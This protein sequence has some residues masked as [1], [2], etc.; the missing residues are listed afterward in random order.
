MERRQSMSVVNY[1]TRGERPVRRTRGATGVQGMTIDPAVIRTSALKVG[2]V[3]TNHE[4]TSGLT[5]GRYTILAASS[6]VQAQH[7]QGFGTG[8]LWPSELG[9]K[10]W[11][12]LDRV[13]GTPGTPS[14]GYMRGATERVL[15]LLAC[16]AWMKA[17]KAGSTVTDPLPLGDSSTAT[18]EFK[19]TPPH[20]S[21][22]PDFAQLAADTVSRYTQIDRVVIWN[23]FKGFWSPTLGR[24]WYEGYTNMYNQCYAA[25]KAVRP[26]VKVG[27]PYMVFNTQG[28][29]FPGDWADDAEPVV[30]DR[31][32]G[33]S[34]AHWGYA[35]KKVLASVKY[36]LANATAADFF[37]MD[38]R[39]STKD[40]AASDAENITYTAAKWDTNPEGGTHPYYW[41]TDPWSAWQKQADM[42][43]WFRSLGAASPSSWGRAGVD[44]RT[45]PFWFMEWYPNSKVNNSTINPNTGTPYPDPVSSDAEKNTVAAEGLRRAALAGY[46]GIMHWRPEGDANGHANPIALWNSSGVATGLAAIDQAFVDNFSAGVDLLSPQNVPANIGVL[47]SATKVLLINKTSSSQTVVVEGV[48]YTLAGWE[49]RVITR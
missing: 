9:A 17:K 23:E 34:P 21:H 45:L 2:W 42:I 40:Y 4:S 46:E 47:A 43:A 48:T 24:W 20:S 10:S 13:F 49:V 35:D 3:H 7:L 8:A 29:E 28:W 12:G 44:S 30:T 25:I 11:G 31:L 22:F 38:L 32:Q 1:A 39:N 15:Y 14:N 41:P 26:A 33:H 27:G 18:G 6:P 36:W 37:A 16:P 19:Y 5:A